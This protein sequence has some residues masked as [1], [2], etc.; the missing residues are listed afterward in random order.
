MKRKRRVLLTLTISGPITVKV[1]GFAVLFA[2]L[3]ITMLL[4]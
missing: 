3:G 1:T 2:A 4:L